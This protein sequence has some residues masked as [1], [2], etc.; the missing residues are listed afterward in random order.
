MSTRRDAVEVILALRE[1][2]LYAQEVGLVSSP[3]RSAAMRLSLHH[4]SALLLDVRMAL[5]ADDTGQ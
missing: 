1:L 2:Q 3:V 4:L 5:D